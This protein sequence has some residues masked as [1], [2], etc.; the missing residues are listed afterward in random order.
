MNIPYVIEQSNRGERAYD[1]YSRL[2]KD[3]IL[4]LGTEINNYSASLIIAQMLYLEADNPEADIN[5]YI[6]SHG[7]QVSD[8]L[9]IYDTMQYIQSPVQTICVGKAF[10]LA[11]ILL[12]SGTQ[13]KRIALK[14]TKILLHQPI[15]GL[16][17]QASDIQIQT[18]E[19]LNV[20][21]NLS[22]ILAKH[23]K[24]TAHAINQD[25]EREFYLDSNEALAYGIVDKVVEKRN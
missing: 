11:A 3:R 16:D 4:F 22:S 5:F 20:K 10:H 14:N 8:G 19:L 17:G 9:A 13:G 1:I 2:L 25:I 23:T 12:A 24:K 21:Q 15:G 7:G 6:N 18:K